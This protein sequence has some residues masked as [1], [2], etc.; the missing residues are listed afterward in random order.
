MEKKDICP[1]FHCSRGFLIKAKWK[2]VG[3]VRHVFWVMIGFVGLV[4]LAQG[5]SII[6]ARIVIS[7]VLYWLWEVVRGLGY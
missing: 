1:D 5:S 3:G 7:L 4:F 6:N 2:T